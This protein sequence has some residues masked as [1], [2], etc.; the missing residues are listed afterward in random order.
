MR[1]AVRQSLTW[2]MRYRSPDPLPG[3]P[4][5]FPELEALIA[6]GWGDV[7]Q[8]QIPDDWQRWSGP[9]EYE[10]SLK[11]EERERRL[12]ARYSELSV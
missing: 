12:A 8:D 4:K 7:P 2:R 6:A 10:R 9:A 1:S 5:Y 3:L 11:A